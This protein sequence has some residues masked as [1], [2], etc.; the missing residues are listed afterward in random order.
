MPRKCTVYLSAGTQAMMGDIAGFARMETSSKVTGLKIAG[1]SSQ[2]FNHRLQAEKGNK[3]NKGFGLLEWTGAV[4]PQGLIVKGAKG[5]WNLAWKTMMTELAPQDDEGSYNRPKY[6]F[7]TDPIASLPVESNRYHIY[8]GNACPWCH[9]VLMALVIRG[10]QEHVSITYAADDPERASRGGWVFDTPEPIF[11]ATDLRQVYDKASPGYRG[12]CTAPLLLDKKTKRIISS[13]SPEILATLFRLQLPGST[14]FD[15]SPSHL[16]EDANQLKALVYNQINNGTY[17]SGF[18]TT[19][20]AY[21]RAQE[22]LY[23]GLEE[24][25]KRLT[26]SRF[27]LGDK[28]TEVDMWLYPTI[29]RF[30]ACYAVLFKCSRRRIS[31]YPHLQAWMRDIYQLQVGPASASNM[32]IKDTFDVDDSRRSYFSSLFPL[33]PGGIVPSG[34]TLADLKLDEDPKRGPKDAAQVFHRKAQLALAA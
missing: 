13:E 27:L 22:Q 2:R 14:H 9:R 19:Q 1:P 17:K 32:Q 18:A 7:R 34:P 6:D 31:D 30:D 12:R 15:L 26:K 28:F 4:I 11:G 20:A 16:D 10:L 5:G 29:I 25:E 23:S 3:V 24:V 21:D 33:N 8:V